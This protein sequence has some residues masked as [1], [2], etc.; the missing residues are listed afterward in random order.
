M[1]PAFTSAMYGNGTDSKPC[2]KGCVASTGFVTLTS[3]GAAKPTE[4]VAVPTGDG[5]ETM[6]DYYRRR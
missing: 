4:Q 5:Y 2:T 6:A 1:E 3:T